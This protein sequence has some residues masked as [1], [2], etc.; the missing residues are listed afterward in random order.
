MAEGGEAKLLRVARDRVETASSTGAARRD[1][2]RDARDD[3]RDLAQEQAA[4]ARIR[5]IANELLS[6]EGRGDWNR[7]RELLGRLLAEAGAEIRGDVQE[8][9][10]DR[11]ERRED[12]RERRR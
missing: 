1:D 9:R 10:E 11:G 8:Q 12:R 3:R 4:D 6:L 2:R 7:K 5:G